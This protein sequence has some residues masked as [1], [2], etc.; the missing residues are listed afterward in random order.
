MSIM[1][2]FTENKLSVTVRE[3]GDFCQVSETTIRKA[4][5]TYNMHTW[6]DARGVIHIRSLDLLK[7]YRHKCDVQLRTMEAKLRTLVNK[8]RAALE[9]YD[10][11]RREYDFQL[12]GEAHGVTKKD[13]QN[14]LDEVDKLHQEVSDASFELYEFL[15]RDCSW[16]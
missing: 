2:N 8:R 12:E 10:D 9:K 15:V 16:I 13:I 11:L 1:Y 4:I 5:K 3:A 14:A 6:K 7:Y